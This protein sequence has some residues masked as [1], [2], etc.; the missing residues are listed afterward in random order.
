MF[1][2]QG[3]VM[4]DY[5]ASRRSILLTCLTEMAAYFTGYLYNPVKGDH[6]YF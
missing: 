1:G 2:Y 5:Q 4:T 6:E 3:C